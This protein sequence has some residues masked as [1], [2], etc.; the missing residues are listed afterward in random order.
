MECESAESGLGGAPERLQG[1]R[2]ETHV[3]MPSQQL[4][5]A[6]LQ[7]DVVR[8]QLNVARLQPDVARLQL[9]VARLQPYVAMLQPHVTVLGQA[10]ASSG[11]P[12]GPEAMKAPRRHR[13]WKLK[14]KRSVLPRAASICR[15][16][17]ACPCGSPKSCRRRHSLWLALFVRKMQ[18]RSWGAKP[19]SR[20]TP[21]PRHHHKLAAATATRKQGDTVV[22][23]AVRTR[24]LT[25]T[26]SPNA[27][28]LL[29]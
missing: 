22:R 28:S 7:P 8:L 23:E 6:K 17:P 12:A 26:M 14:R 19:S 10:E 3:M 20:E 1:R 18:P 2:C 5:V 9:N 11:K 25:L 15:S 27:Y 21:R 16:K 13:L 4:D 29:L 24:L